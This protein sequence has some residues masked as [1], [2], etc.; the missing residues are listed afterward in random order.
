LYIFES[1]NYR[2]KVVHHK[3]MRFNVSNILPNYGFS[4]LIMSFTKLQIY[5]RL[6]V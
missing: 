4:A 1:Q 3:T 5:K 6:N 2:F